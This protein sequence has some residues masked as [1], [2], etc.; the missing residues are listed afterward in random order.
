MTIDLI[1]P[2]DVLFFA[3]VRDAMFS[4]AK[5]YGLPLKSVEVTPQASLKTA[6]MGTCSS[7][8]DIRLTIRAKNPDGTWTEPMSPME[9]W[10]T[11][12]HE[13]AHL[14]HFNHGLE[15][16]EFELEMVQALEIRRE[17]PTQKIINRIVKLQKQADGEAHLGNAAAAESFA[18]MANKLL[19]DHELSASDLDYGRKSTDD[20]IIEKYVNFGAYKMKKTKTRIGWQEALAR[21]VAN[22]HLCSFL[23]IPGSNQIIFV[24]TKSHATVAEYVFGTM[25][26]AVDKMADVEY[27]AFY[28]RMAAAG[29][30]AEARGYR[31]GWLDAFVTRIGQRFQEEREAAIQRAHVDNAMPSSTSLMRISGSMTRV[32]E[33][34]DNKFASRRKTYVGEVKFRHNHAAGQRDGKAAADRINLGRR[35]VAGGGSRGQLG[36]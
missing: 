9:I 6:H 22:A 11:A 27:Y 16:Q 29:R 19:L 20:P 35:G 18:A 30:G 7:T 25:V 23:L 4:V 13:L 21:L 2:D 1:H 8:G 28:N 33:Y 34:I 14:K 36:S 26:P 12:G 15:F 32:R 17:D 10:K 3:S 31:K 24:G 5:E